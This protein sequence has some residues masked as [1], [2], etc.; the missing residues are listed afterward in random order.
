MKGNMVCQKAHVGPV[1][2]T[3]AFNSASKLLLPKYI[4]D[5]DVYVKYKTMIIIIIDT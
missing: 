1:P 2:L 4:D 3:S 5:V